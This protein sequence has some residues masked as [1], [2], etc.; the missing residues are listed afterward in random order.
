MAECT[1][2]AV[3]PLKKALKTM[4][5]RV[6]T[7]TLNEIKSKLA[8]I[9]AVGKP[10]TFAVGGVSG[11]CIEWLNANSC[12]WILRYRKDGKACR[13]MLGAY[14]TLTLKEARTKATEILEN[15]GERP[16]VPSGQVETRP[17]V[18]EL[19]PQFVA[20][21]I[22]AGE[23]KDPRAQS[24]KMNFGV[25][26]VFPYV[27]GLDPEQI[28]YQHVA[29]M[30]NAAV[31]KS[32]Q[33]KSLTILRQFLQWCLPRGYRVNEHLPTDRG[34][35][36]TLCADMSE[37]GGNMPALAWQDVPRFVAALTDGGLQGIGSAALLFKILTASRS[38][39]IHKADWR[40]VSADLSQWVCPA[41]HM[42]VKRNKDGSRAADHVV[43]LSAQARAVLL[44]VRS[45]GRESGLIFGIGERQKEMS[46]NT[47][48]KRIKDLTRQAER[49]G[50]AGFRDKVTG[51]VV[52]PHGFRSSFQTWA[53]ENGK[54]FHVSDYCLAHADKRDKYQGAYMRAS[55]LPQRQELLQ[56]WADYCLSQCSA[57]WCKW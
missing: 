35:L 6:R 39:P 50:E 47:M 3:L 52:C 40:E 24:V 28:T 14:A 46:N 18:A 27:G 7:F 56:A 10:V 4:P 33:D 5:K 9:A 55:M 16:S 42:K 12:R 11:L 31:S 26:H 51:E 38:E 45:L 57:D 25:K 8:E 48:S 36:K 49:R 20:A 22:T 29:A 17:T 13:L 32:G 15:G 43:P 41:E 19:W 54:D 37:T 23:W 30:L 21:M 53:V 44:L 2:N 1:Q 34:V